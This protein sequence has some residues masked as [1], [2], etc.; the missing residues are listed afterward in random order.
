MVLERGPEQGGIL[1]GD[2]LALRP[3]DGHIDLQP[4]PCVDGL[5]WLT[6][7]L[8]GE[9]RALTGDNLV[10]GH[11][12]RGFCFVDAGETDPQWCSELF[13]AA[14]YD[15][16]VNGEVVVCTEEDGSE[17]LMV[18][19]RKRNY[20]DVRTLH[21]PMPPTRRPHSLV[22]EAFPTPLR[23]CSIYFHLAGV[24][25]FMGLAKEAHPS[26]WVHKRIAGWEKA[27][28]DHGLAGHVQRPTTDAQAAKRRR[29]EL[30]DKPEVNCDLSKPA[31]SSV[32]LV[33][34]LMRWSFNDR[35]HGGFGEAGERS[36]AAWA[37]TGLIDALPKAPFILRLFLGGHQPWKPPR[38]LSGAIPLLLEVDE[39]KRISLPAIPAG[40][41]QAQRGFL[42][43]HIGWAEGV[44][45][46]LGAFVEA[47]TKGCTSK[48]WWHLADQLAI[49]IGLLL[50]EAIAAPF[51]WEFARAPQGGF[52][53]EKSS[54]ET[55]AP[56]DLHSLRYWHSGRAA[57]SMHS[58]MPW[59]VAT[60]G[61]RAG[62]RC[63]VNGC[64]VFPTNVALQLPPAV[65]LSA[66]GSD[67]W[68]Q[69]SSPQAGACSCS[70]PNLSWCPSNLGIVHCRG[71]GV[72]RVPHRPET[73]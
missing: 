55:V 35:R 8:T 24:S 9:V 60:D 28:A 20:M 49:G 2:D 21:L 12:D 16:L 56:R 11:D 1:P 47:V 38:I 66:S 6:S 67:S 64:L 50:D 71:L 42:L 58:S 65:H 30:A 23:G 69:V 13:R 39:T 54:K 7:D 10:L 29:T 52:S 46:P 32:G 14:L 40:V 34:L 26:V 18:A 37:L 25:E 72:G 43:D 4:D 45:V 27:I 44:V 36:Q 17:V 33:F 70:F 31:A 57:A 5:W 51:D 63:M 22:V 15:S 53:W 68:A 59:C 41:T 73:G 48:A 61:T 3:D 62:G 19:A